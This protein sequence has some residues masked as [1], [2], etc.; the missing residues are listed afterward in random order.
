MRSKCIDSRLSERKLC[1]K[2]NLM[3]DIPKSLKGYLLLDGGK[4]SGSFFHRTVVLV[5]QHDSEGALGLVLNRNSGTKIGE[6]IVADLPDTLKEQALFIGGPVQPE[7]MSFLHSDSF[8]PEANV[9]ANLNLSHS[10]EDLVE[11]AADFSP[12]KQLRVF[13]GYS[14]WA[15]GQ[16]EEEMKRGAWVSHP[17]T[18]ELVFNSDPDALWK[19][20]LRKKGWQERLAA[21]TP[22]DLSWN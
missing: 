22:P 11:V 9:I 14:G 2:F 19:E 21:E 1:A 5:C 16:L 10:L 3:V 8:L 20:I 18:V 17:A 7:A 15:G 13:A 6:A 12:T 4:L